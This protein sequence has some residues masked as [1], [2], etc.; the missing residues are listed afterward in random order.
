TLDT[1]SNFMVVYQALKEAN[2]PLEVEVTA[3]TDPAEGDKATLLGRLAREQGWRT[4]S[5]PDGVGGR[6]SVF[7]EV[8]LLTGVAVGFDI[9][10]FLAGARAMDVACR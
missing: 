8:G 10:E 9:D 3:V 7:S 4:F 5:V 2:V 1:M 6:F